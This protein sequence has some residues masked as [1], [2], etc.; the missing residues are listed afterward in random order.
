[1]ADIAMTSGNRSSRSLSA[2]LAITYPR[3]D[4]ADAGL[5]LALR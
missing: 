3:S 2:S 1:M 4:G 5:V